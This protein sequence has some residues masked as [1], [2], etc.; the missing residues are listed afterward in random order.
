MMKCA[1]PFAAFAAGRMSFSQTSYISARRYSD[2]SAMPRRS[3]SAAHLAHCPN[4]SPHTENRKSSRI[5]VSKTFAARAHSS[6][7]R[8]RAFGSL[9]HTTICAS[10]A[11]GAGSF[12]IVGVIMPQTSKPAARKASRSSTSRSVGTRSPWR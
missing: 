12:S 9:Q 11:P 4:G 1:A 5:T 6:R 10:F 8:S 3:L 2:Q 7:M